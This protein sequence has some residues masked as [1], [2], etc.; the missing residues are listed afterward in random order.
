[1]YSLGI[2]RAGNYSRED[3]E[4]IGRRIASSFQGRIGSVEIENFPDTD[5]LEKYFVREDGMSAFDLVFISHFVEQYYPRND[6]LLCIIPYPIS[7]PNRGTFA[8]GLCT[9]Q[10][11]P[12]F[13]ST[14][15]HYMSP[16][17]PAFTS[18]VSKVGAHEIGHY[19]GLEHHER[20]AATGS[21]KPCLM[22]PVPAFENEAP[23][24]VMDRQ[25]YRFCKHCYDKLPA[26]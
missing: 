17:M 8:D 10:S 23:G 1:M 2:V 26:R 24:T 16:G 19:F 6:M 18:R 22:S 13:V 11:R 15:Q 5:M 12:S 9:T 25:D 14:Y 7:G 4:D 21:G 20:L 3:L